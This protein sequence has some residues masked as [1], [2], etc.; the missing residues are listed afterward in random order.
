[1]IERLFV[2]YI[3]TDLLSAW[4]WLNTDLERGGW[5]WYR[6]RNDLRKTHYLL[7]IACLKAHLRMLG[8]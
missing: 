8:A 1:M 3:M 6:H 2:K 4:K 7:E 5:R